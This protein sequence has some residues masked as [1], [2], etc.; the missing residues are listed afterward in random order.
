MGPPGEFTA[1][2]A[3][4]AKGELE[5]PKHCS[6]CVLTALCDKRSKGAKGPTLISLRPF[7]PFAMKT[8]LLNIEL[9]RMQQRVR[10]H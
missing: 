7:A 6:F 5:K 10:F 8:F 1:K 9:L 3:K 2:G 4:N